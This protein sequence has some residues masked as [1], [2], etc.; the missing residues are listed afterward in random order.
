MAPVC[1]F[2][3]LA[4]G[5][6]LRCPTLSAALPGATQIPC[7]DPPSSVPAPIPSSWKREGPMLWKW[8]CLQITSTDPSDA[9]PPARRCSSCHQLHGRATVHESPVSYMAFAAQRPCYSHILPPPSGSLPCFSDARLRGYY[10]R[11]AAASDDDDQHALPRW[12][13]ARRKKASRFAPSVCRK[14]QRRRTA[15]RISTHRIL[16]HLISN[17]IKVHLTPTDVPFPFPLLLWLSSITSF[18][19]SLCSSLRLP[20]GQAVLCN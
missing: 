15:T 8:T 4:C 2:Q 10:S 17:Y 6:L 16:S 7:L 14:K 18:T 13:L 19:H 3:T 1:H 20:S 11:R 9:T 5:V 12:D